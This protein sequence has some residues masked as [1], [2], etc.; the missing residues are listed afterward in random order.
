ML[1][2]YICLEKEINIAGKYRAVSAI[3][4]QF[5]FIK[6]H[7]VYFYNISLDNL[8]LKL[9]QSMLNYSNV[10]FYALFLFLIHPMLVYLY[11]CENITAL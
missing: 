4:L 6:I 2:F 9:P 5:I 8:S 3:C 7:F 10:K 1:Y 11:H